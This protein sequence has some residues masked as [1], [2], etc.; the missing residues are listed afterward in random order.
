MPKTPTAITDMDLAEKAIRRLPKEA[1]VEI[2]LY[3]FGGLWSDE[4]GNVSADNEFSPDAERWLRY[5][6]HMCAVMDEYGLTP[7][8]PS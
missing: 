3:A 4:D 2:V 7:D 6:D 5:A 1:L 8:I